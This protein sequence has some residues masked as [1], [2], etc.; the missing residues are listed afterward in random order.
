MQTTSVN[1]LCWDDC[2]QFERL[3]YFFGK[4]MTKRDFQAEQSYFNE[5]R[6]IMNRLGL[7]WGVLCGL[8]VRPCRSN[9]NRIIVEKGFA[10]DKYG[11]EIMVCEEQVVE[12]RTAADDCESQEKPDKHPCYYIGLRYME[13]SVEPTPVPVEDCCSLGSECEYNRTRE[14]YE[15]KVSLDPFTEESECLPRDEFNCEI[16]CFRKLED[17]CRMVIEQCPERVQCKV[18][19][20]AKVC[21]DADCEQGEKPIPK[22][23][24]YNCPPYRQ[25][26]FS[27]ENLYQLMICLKEE[28]WKAHAARY[29]RRQYVPLLAQTLKGIRYRSGRILTIPNVGYHL[30]RLTTDGDT[31]WITD[32]EKPAVIVLGKDTGDVE[33]SSLVSLRGNAWGIAFDGKYMWVTHHETHPGRLSRINICDEKD[34]KTFTI[35]NI[36]DPREIVFDGQYLW[37]S[38]RQV[39]EKGQA[40]QDQTPVQ[41]QQQEPIDEKCI[42]VS[43]IDPCNLN[44]EPT[45]N[46]CPYDWCVPVSPASLAGMVFDGNSIWVTYQAFIGKKET[47]VV[48]KIATENGELGD[49][50]EIDGSAPEDITFDG[51]HVW[52]AH[53]EGVSKVDIEKE[54]EIASA[55]QRKQTAIAFDGSMLWTAELGSGEARVNRINTFSVEFE[56]GEEMI[57]YDEHSYD[58]DISRLCFDGSFI[59]VAANKT[60]EEKPGI[61]HRLLP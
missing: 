12:L 57:K 46:I 56:G 29:D 20:L 55:T 37:V 43:K 19:P 52:V 40:A 54:E 32:S 51:T 44:A 47:A 35:Q 22:I 25:L 5:K 27:N 59:W 50:V 2:L 41:Q 9:E 30:N 48:Q 58:Y 16:T 15:F 3:N 4:L 61:V 11:H 21:F 13:C 31:V 39:G 18:I 6:W 38:H 33:K 26:A 60:G 8:K 1:E 42:Y 36:S 10:L 49:P 28:L 14:S 34:V 7:G 23:V 24:I 17:P 45:I 53:D